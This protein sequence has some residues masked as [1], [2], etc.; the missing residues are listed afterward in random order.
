MCYDKPDYEGGR[1]A[2]PGQNPPALSGARA[3]V[4]KVIDLELIQWIVLLNVCLAVLFGVA[5]FYQLVYLVIGLA[6]RLRRR[7]RQRGEAPLHRYAAVVAARNEA[8]V[9]GE[10]LRTLR[11]QKYPAEMLDLYVIADNCTD[12]TAQV[13]TQAG[14]TV[15]RRFNRVRKG[16]GYALDEFFRWLARDGRDR[17][18]AYLIFDADNLVD[19]NFVGEMNRVFATGKYDAITSYRNSRNFGTNWISAGYALWFLR[20]ARFLSAPRMALG[21][22]CHVSGTGFLV[23]ARTIRENGG[24]PFHL[25]T[26][27]IQFSVDCAV[28]GRRIGYCDRAVIYDEQPTTF[29]QSLDQ[30]LRWSKGF[31]QVEAQY[32]LPLLRGMARG[33]RRGWACYDMLMTVAPGMLLTLAVLLFNLLVCGAV[34]FEPTYVARQ[35]VAVALEFLWSMVSGFYVGLFLYGLL[36]TLTEWRQI[37]AGT[38]KKIL[39][40]FTFPLFMF[41]YV[42]ISLAALVKRVEWKPIY[43]T[44]GKKMARELP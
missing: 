7:P 20:E 32:T 18:D 29:R 21:S 24:W 6:G 4:F 37:H 14:A 26:E 15:Y 2:R 35:V 42:P 27:D 16:K 41:T 36:T 43:H 19:H 39:S 12:D 34:L 31:Y 8:G 17:Y 22:N 33:G 25:L 38:G 9:I 13:A 28:R 3:R 11:E 1:P 10:L 5:Y 44:G 40:L 23:S 30:R